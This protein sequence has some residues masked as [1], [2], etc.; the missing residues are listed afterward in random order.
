[1]FAFPCYYQELPWI[2]LN[3]SLNNCIKLP[4]TNIP[5]S[6]S[7]N[8]SAEYPDFIVHTYGLQIDLIN[9]SELT[10]LFE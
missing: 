4:A 7:A 8:R 6:S 2:Y 3:I 5:S 9:C 1:M 10:H